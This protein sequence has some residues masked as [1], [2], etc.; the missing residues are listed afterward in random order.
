VSLWVLQKIKAIPAPGETF[1]I[2]GLEVSIA[3]ATHRSID[4]VHIRLKQDEMPGH[5]TS[6]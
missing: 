5:T 6:D 1:V 2:D 4:K 3:E